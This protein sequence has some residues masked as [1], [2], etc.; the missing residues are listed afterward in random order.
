L[1]VLVRT[2][3]VKNLSHFWKWKLDSLGN[4]VIILPLLSDAGQHPLKG[5]MTTRSPFLFLKF[6]NEYGQMHVLWTTAHFPISGFRKHSSVCPDYE[7]VPVAVFGL[8]LTLPGEHLFLAL[9]TQLAIS[10]YT[11]RLDKSV[12]VWCFVSSYL[13]LYHALR[14]C[15]NWL[16]SSWNQPICFS[17]QPTTQLVI[18]SYGPFVF[19]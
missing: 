14:F 3:E 19:K 13:D 10:S 16:F 18:C 8:T 6:E 2:S 9:F 15:S 17:R 1:T 12:H 4:F 11:V 5:K 7:F